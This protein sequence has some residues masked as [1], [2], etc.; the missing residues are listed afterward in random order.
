M[1]LLSFF[2]FAIFGCEDR[3][4]FL[5]PTHK[6]S[7]PHALSDSPTTTRTTP[8][9]DQILN[10]NSFCVSQQWRGMHSACLSFS[11]STFSDKVR[12]ETGRETF[13]VGAVKKD[14]RKQHMAIYRYNVACCLVIIDCGETPFLSAFSAIGGARVAARETCTT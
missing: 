1:F 8:S 12:N 5:P 14:S 13:Y 11:T 10:S 7:T 9:R 2:G 6:H 3:T 4:K